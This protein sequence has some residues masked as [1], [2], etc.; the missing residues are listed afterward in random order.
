MP[1]LPARPSQEHLRKQAK[2]LARERSI[3]VA[4]AQQLLARDYGFRTWADL[5]RHVANARG[6]EAN[7]PS[8]LFAAI[9]AADVDTVRR[10]LAKGV[11][12][13][14]GDGRESSLHAAA[15]AG[16]L[17]VV[18]VLIEG[19][20]LD[21]Q[22]DAKGRTPAEVA[23]KTKGPER[24]AIVA[25]LDSTHIADPSFRAAVDTI[26]AGD[27]A[28]LEALLDAEPRLL[29]ERIVGPEAYRKASRPQ[30]FRDPKL[31]WFVANNPTLVRKMPPNITEI[32]S[33]MISRGVD[34]E[35]LD[36]TLGLVMTSS[37]A[38]EQ[39]HQRPLMDLLLAAGAKPARDE[40]LVTAAHRELE[41]LR[42]LVDLGYPITAPIAA[43]FGDDAALANLLP[44]ADTTDI[45]DAFG[46]AVINGRLAAARSAL[47]AGA[48]VNAF[49]PVHAHGTALHTAAIADDVAMIDLLLAHGAR[50]DIRDKLWDATPL[51]WAI[52]ENRPAARARLDAIA[53][54]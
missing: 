28:K 27:V 3:R 4:E 36:Y 20:A 53:K 25:V 42:A 7:I 49:L 47:K 38:R 21:W 50:T 41:A 31:F 13:R 9:R 6:V 2:R 5:K 37:V 24:E 46:L 11:N 26:H 29:R 35:D 10:L 14:V 32:A 17:A 12:P 30:Y 39:G 1:A 34:R 54:Q 22:T 16:S 48:D 18:E 15:R 51:G 43:S 52:H 19:G 40:I 33:A 44:V 8:P 45:Q 23:R